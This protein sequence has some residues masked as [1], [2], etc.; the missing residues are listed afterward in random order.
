MI[1]RLIIILSLLLLGLQIPGSASAQRIRMSYA[2]TT[3]FNVPFWLAHEAG[4]FKKH[5]LSEDLILISGGATNIQALL[6]GEI[7][8][9]NAA[10]SAPIQATLQGAEVTIIATSY[11]VMPYGFVVGKDIRSPADLKGKTLAVSRLGGITEVAARLALEKMGLGPNAMTLIQAGP[12]GP[13]IVALQSGAVA[14]TLLAPPALFAAA[15]SGLRILADLGDLG[16]EY[17]TSVN[18]VSRRYLAQNRSAVKKY[19]MALVESLHLYKE[20]RQLAVQVSRKYTK[21]DDQELLSKT[22]D[23]FVKNT[24][25]MPL[26]GA[27]VIQNGLPA[28]G[29]REKKTTDFF[30]NSVLE[31]LIKEGFVKKITS[32]RS[33]SGTV[34][35]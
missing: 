12:D 20:N 2:G 3:G 7:Q 8:F 16:I 34:S 21:L 6:A 9:A 27:A 26:T 17:P 15:S 11:N 31:E 18:V 24:S 30:D 10:G 4:L 33:K 19:L 23:Y 35:R 5:G 28:G 14:A 32:V 29:E 1:A 25:F 22:Y 13:R